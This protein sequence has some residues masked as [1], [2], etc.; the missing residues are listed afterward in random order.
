MLLR[1]QKPHKSETFLEVIGF[2]CFSEAVDCRLGI[3][4]IE[5]SRIAITSGIHLF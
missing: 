5:D 2:W 3:L 1:T 4:E